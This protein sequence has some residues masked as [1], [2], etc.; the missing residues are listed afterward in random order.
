MN[1]ILTIPYVKYLFYSR[2]NQTHFY[3]T[4]LTINLHQYFSNFWLNIWIVFGVQFVT[5]TLHVETLV[6]GQTAAIDLC[7]MNIL[8]VQNTIG[9]FATTVC[10]ESR[11]KS[12]I[13]YFFI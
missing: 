3:L 7:F 4:F 5:L 8:E 9:L 11:S 6:D 10:N 12:Q 1:H 13:L 2:G